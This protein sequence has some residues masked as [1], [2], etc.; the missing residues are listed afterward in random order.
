MI[1]RLLPLLTLGRKLIMIVGFH[2]KADPKV[3]I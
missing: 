3:I 2:L 1:G